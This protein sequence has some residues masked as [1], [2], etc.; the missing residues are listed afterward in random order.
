MPFSY[1]HYR[2][3]YRANDKL[4]TMHPMERISVDVGSSRRTLLSTDTSK[5]V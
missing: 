3:Q 1:Y 5:Y 2:Y 4:V